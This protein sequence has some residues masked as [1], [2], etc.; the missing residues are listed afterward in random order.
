M[1]FHFY[2]GD[3]ILAYSWY[4]VVM[5]DATAFRD[6]IGY[7]IFTSEFWL[8]FIMKQYEFVFCPLY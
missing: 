1:R 3:V 4:L 5:V 6:K 8:T 7:Y 2:F